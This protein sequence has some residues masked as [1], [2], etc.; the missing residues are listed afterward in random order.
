MRNNGS[1]NKT[2]EIYIADNNLLN[3]QK[4][5]QSDSIN[6]KLRRIKAYWKVARAKNYAGLIELFK[7]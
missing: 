7:M 4:F 1:A 3:E 5:I 2:V 6:C